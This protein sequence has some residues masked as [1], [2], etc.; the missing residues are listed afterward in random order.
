MSFEISH[1][2]K[3]LTS[4]VSYIQNQLKARRDRIVNISFTFFR[5]QIFCSKLQSIIASMTST[6]NISHLAHN[7]HQSTDISIHITDLKKA[8]RYL[9]HSSRF[10]QSV[11]MFM[12]SN[13]SKRRITSSNCKY[14]SACLA[15]RLRT[16]IRER[17]HLFYFVFILI[18]NEHRMH[19]LRFIEE[20]AL[21]SY[22]RTRYL[23]IFQ[24][25]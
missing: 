13:I 11:S 5:H 1:L 7:R 24:L 16:E 17:F 19:A 25:F 21:L 3:M 15:I 22:K 6:S 20:N 8:N 12:I 10:F 14:F 18:I 2:I 4:L 9:E 23:C